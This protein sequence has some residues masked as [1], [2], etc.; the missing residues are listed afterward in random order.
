MSSRVELLRTLVT[1][2][3]TLAVIAG[4]IVSAVAG[5]DV[6]P[7]DEWGAVIIGYWFGAG[8]QQAVAKAANA[9]RVLSVL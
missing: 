9:D 1:A 3:I 8:A 7:L 5:S 4:V 6:G 2:A